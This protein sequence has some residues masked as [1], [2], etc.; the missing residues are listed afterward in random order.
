MNLISLHSLIR[1][2]DAAKEYLQ[3]QGILKRQSSCPKCSEPMTKEIT[4]WWGDF[5]KYGRKDT[6]VLGEGFFGIKF[7]KLW[8]RLKITNKVTKYLW[9]ADSTWNSFF[10]LYYNWFQHKVL[11]TKFCN[12]STVLMMGFILGVLFHYLQNPKTIVDGRNYV[13]VGQKL[14]LTLNAFLLFL[15]TILTFTLQ[16]P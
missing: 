11:L 16:L 14:N 10:P 6:L 2:E 7:L 9:K 8:W 5:E 15:L 13:H 4:K 12:A 1:D 3:T